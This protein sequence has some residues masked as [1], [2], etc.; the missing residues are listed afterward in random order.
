[1]AALNKAGKANGLQLMLY[2]VEKGEREERENGEESGESSR[3]KEIT[4]DL[5][6]NNN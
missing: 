6:N 5:T 4:V 3:S 1:M 2:R